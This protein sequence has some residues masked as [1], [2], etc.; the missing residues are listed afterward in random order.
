VALYTTKNPAWA[1]HGGVDLARGDGRPLTTKRDRRAPRA[2]YEQRWKMFGRI[3]Q[4]VPAGSGSE[5]AARPL[6]GRAQES[7]HHRAFDYR[8][9]N[10]T[11]TLSAGDIW[12]RLSDRVSMQNA[13]EQNGRCPRH[14]GYMGSRCWGVRNMEAGKLTSGLRMA[15]ASDLIATA[16]MEPKRVEPDG[17]G[18]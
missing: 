10:A 1:P 14:C 18:V 12:T 2:I 5:T 13:L 17:V 16:S 8:N 3:E 11:A 15:T 4:F 6:H 9:I 7:E